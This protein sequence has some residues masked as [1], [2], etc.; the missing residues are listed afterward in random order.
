MTDRQGERRFVQLSPEKIRTTRFGRTS[1]TRRGLS[2]DEVYGFL[3]RVAEEM[4]ILQTEV[5]SQRAENDRLKGALRDWQ[6]QYRGE[7]GRTEPTGPTSEAIALMARAQQ[8]IDAQVA[9][10]ELY[11]RR[12]EQEAL[13]KYDEILADANRRAHEEAERAAHRYR[14]TAGPGGYSADQEQLQRQ[15]V[16]LNALLLAFDALSAHMDAT[17]QAFAMEVEKLGVDETPAR[18]PAHP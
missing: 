16:Y 10:A 5:A 11:C 12:R 4:S 9:E 15:R 13:A 7:A 18:P 8:Q 3:L 2:E 17:R 14:A 1:M 6:Q